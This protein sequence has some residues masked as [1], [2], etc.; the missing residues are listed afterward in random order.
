MGGEG[1][2]GIGEL[3]E[4]GNKKLFYNKTILDYNYPINRVITCC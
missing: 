2:W 3:G 4:W 1:D